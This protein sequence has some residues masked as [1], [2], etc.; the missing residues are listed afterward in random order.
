M[1]QIESVLLFSILTG[2]FYEIFNLYFDK[3]KVVRI[4]NSGQNQK[5]KV[6]YN[7]FI[8]SARLFMKTET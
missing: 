4:Y 8:I 6:L 7:I 5:S 3:L 1:W 2:Q